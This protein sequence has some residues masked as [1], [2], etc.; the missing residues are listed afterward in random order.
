MNLHLLWV[1]LLA[2]SLQN[3]N[4]VKPNPETPRKTK[5]RNQRQQLKPPEGTEG[6]SWG[7]FI[8]E[9]RLREWLANHDSEDVS[10]PEN[11]AQGFGL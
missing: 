7:F 8:C 2:I 4:E 10:V 3:K 9:V 6:G 5:K 1:F 11:K